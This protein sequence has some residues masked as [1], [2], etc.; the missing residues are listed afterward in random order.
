MTNSHLLPEMPKEF[1]ALV[2]HINLWLFVYESKYIRHTHTG[3]V[4]AGP[5]GK[6]YPSE[7]DDYIYQK[8]AEYRKLLNK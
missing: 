8:A 5:K 4:Y 7:A 2:D 1:L 6:K 3:P